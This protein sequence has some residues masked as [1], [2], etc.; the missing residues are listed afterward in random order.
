MSSLLYIPTKIHYKV[1]L[2]KAQWK[3]ELNITYTSHKKLPK[4]LLATQVL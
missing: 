4:T 2:G 3:K 1:R